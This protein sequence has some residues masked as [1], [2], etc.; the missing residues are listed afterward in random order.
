MWKKKHKSTKTKTHLTETIK[1]SKTN[2]F[3]RRK[4]FERSILFH[5]CETR[6]S[7]M[8]IKTKP[9]WEKSQMIQIKAKKKIPNN[10]PITLTK[11]KSHLCEIAIQGFYWKEKNEITKWHERVLHGLLRFEEIFKLG[12]GTANLLH[13]LSDQGKITPQIEGSELSTDYSGI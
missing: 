4:K 7:R 12:F 2:L 3:H 1:W 8:A 5:N 10:K 13:S 11:Q 6:S 9:K